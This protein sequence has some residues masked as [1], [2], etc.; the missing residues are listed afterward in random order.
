MPA[1]VADRY[2]LPGVVFRPLAEPAPAC[3][4][5]LIGGPEPT[6]A[7]MQLDKLVREAA[8]TVRPVRAEPVLELVG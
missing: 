8:A 2:S 5:A 4:V 7:S 3:D 6:T 1:S